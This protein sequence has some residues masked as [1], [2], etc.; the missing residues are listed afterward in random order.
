[1]TINLNKKTIFISMPSYNEQHLELTI[2]GCLE[3]AEFPERIFIGAWV[4]NNDGNKNEFLSKYKNV[5]YAR[6]DY[7][8]VL[9]V[10]VGRLNALTF[11]NN[12]D[13]YFQ[14]DPHMVFKKNWDSILIES[15]EELKKDYEKPIISTWVPYWYMSNMEIK[16][17]GGEYCTRLYWN[18][19]PKYPCPIPDGGPQ[20]W[21]DGE[22]FKEHY[23]IGA[24]F[25]FTSP[26]FIQEILPDTLIQFTGDE[27]TTAFRSWTRGYRIFCM[28]ETVAWHLDRFHPDSDPPYKYDRIMGNP[29]YAPQHIKDHEEHRYQD[30]L[31]R[32]K[33]IL[34][35]EILGYWGSPTMDLLE[36]YQLASNINFFEF[37]KKRN[38][39]LMNYS[40][41]NKGGII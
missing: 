3:N 10:G 29:D 39:Y 12:E 26:D 15:F 6:V 21:Q 14:I 23:L 2:K 24:H 1:M 25:V 41:I 4:H 33:K 5:K 31:L 9:G 30:S 34:T 32:V 38:E 7:P 16:K 13:Y 37:Y 36:E 19:D 35:G 18:K 28:K 40:L 17:G 27:T 11:Y 22:K 8:V 20:D